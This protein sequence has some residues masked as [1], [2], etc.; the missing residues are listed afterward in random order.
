MPRIDA[1]YQQAL[2][3]ECNRMRTDLNKIRMIAAEPPADGHDQTA[4]YRIGMISAY[5]LDGLNLLHPRGQIGP[6]AGESLP[7]RK[8]GDE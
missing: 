6:A 8:E 1:R 2:E 3:E 5:A 7:P 4:W